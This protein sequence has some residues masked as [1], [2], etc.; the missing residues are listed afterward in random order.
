MRLRVIARDR[1]VCSKHSPIEIRFWSVLVFPIKF[2]SDLNFLN[3]RFHFAIEANGR[4]TLSLMDASL[5]PGVREGS[6]FAN[7]YFEI[8]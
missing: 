3:D 4:K 8:F 2:S 6:V 7:N 1:K 5:F